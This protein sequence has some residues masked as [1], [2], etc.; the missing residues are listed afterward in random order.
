MSADAVSKGLDAGAANGPRQ[1]LADHHREIEVACR[2]M[3]AC[4]YADDPL[5]LIEQYRVFERAILD[6]LGAEE[7]MILPA[8]AE[9]APA[10]ARALRDDHAALR[11]Q[12]FQLGVE[13]ELHL[14]RAQTLCEL[15]DQLHAHAAREDA[16]MYP[17]SQLHLPLA[18]KRQLFDRISQS[19]RLLAQRVAARSTQPTE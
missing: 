5:Q 11:Q 2:E 15:I 3:L 17:W 16:S 4:T 10:D 8:Y 14:V 9:A 7:E 19:L 18:S 6:H 12:L 1:L 13:V